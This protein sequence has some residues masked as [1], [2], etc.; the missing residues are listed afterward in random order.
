MI[1]NTMKNISGKLVST[2]KWSTKAIRDFVVKHPIAG[3][4]KMGDLSTDL[5]VQFRNNEEFHKVYDQ[6]KGGMDMIATCIGSVIS[7]NAITPVIRNHFGAD[8]QKAS[9][10]HDSM[11]KKR[12]YILTKQLGY[13]KPSG[14]MKI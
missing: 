4:S 8:R 6:F 11:Q 9:I 10:S 1:T 12:D 3:N 2:G 7:C 13:Y 5:G 14:S